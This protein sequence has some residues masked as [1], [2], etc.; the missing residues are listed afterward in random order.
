[1]ISVPDNTSFGDN[2]LSQ[3][4]TVEC[5]DYTSSHPVSVGSYTCV[6]S[7]ES[8]PFCLRDSCNNRHELT[9]LPVLTD[10]LDIPVPAMCVEGGT[11]ANTGD[12][13]GWRVGEWRGKVEVEYN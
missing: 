2:K 5:P 13:E 6:G 12:G 1:M 4:S 3:R 10:H 7:G 11:D 8:S 9:Q